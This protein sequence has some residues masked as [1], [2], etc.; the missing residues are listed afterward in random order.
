[1]PISVAQF[2]AVRVTESGYCRTAESTAACAASPCS[3]LK[4]E[5]KAAGQAVIEQRI[6][7][8]RAA[9][10]IVDHQRVSIPCLP[11]G[12]DSDVRETVGD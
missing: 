8:S 5:A 4:K 3:S 1:M 11:I 9:A 10:D 12:D 7:F 6:L 2:I